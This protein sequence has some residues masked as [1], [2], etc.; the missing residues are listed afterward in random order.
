MRLPTHLC[1]S[2]KY[3]S[4]LPGSSVLRDLLQ[5][6]V[7]S[8]FSVHLGPIG[9]TRFPDRGG[10]GFDLRPDFLSTRCLAS[11]SCLGSS[12]FPFCRFD[13]WSDVA[14]PNFGCRRQSVFVRLSPTIASF[15][16]PEPK[17]VLKGQ[18]TPSNEGTDTAPHFGLCASR[19][20]KIG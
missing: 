7:F 8:S 19:V 9:F 20:L 2:A 6:W 18:K 4:F 1:R 12:D 11:D 13:F 3:F 16:D 17:W 15:G 10:T 14:W 5:G